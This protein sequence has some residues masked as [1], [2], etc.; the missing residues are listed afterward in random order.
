M[1]FVCQLF[2][3]GQVSL[4]RQLQVSIFV[5]LDLSFRTFITVHMSVGIDIRHTAVAN[6]HIDL[7][8]MSMEFV[9]TLV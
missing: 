4:L 7:V 8:K 2:G 9:I 5:S 3:R 1:L 6:F